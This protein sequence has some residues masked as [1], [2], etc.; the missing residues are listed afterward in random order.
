MHQAL[1]IGV[2]NVERDIVREQRKDHGDHG[3]ESAGRMGI[4]PNS[5]EPRKYQLRGARRANLTATNSS[6]DDLE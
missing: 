4:T 5:V 6:R 1:K 3:A 2:R